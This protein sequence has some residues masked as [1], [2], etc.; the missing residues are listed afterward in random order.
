VSWGK[1]T[2]QVYILRQNNGT[3]GIFGP[4]EALCGVCKINQHCFFSSMFCLFWP[5]DVAGILHK[6]FKKCPCKLLSVKTAQTWNFVWPSQLAL[7]VQWIEV[8]DGVAVVSS[9]PVVGAEVP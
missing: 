1:K 6:Y 2:W 5:L 9:V 7:S 4:D 8:A 3:D